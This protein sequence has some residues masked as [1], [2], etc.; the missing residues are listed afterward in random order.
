MYLPLLSVLVIIF[1]YD[2]LHISN[3]RSY[4]F[5]FIIIIV[6]TWFFR[7]HNSDYL[8]YLEFYNLV[9]SSSIED[10]F[11]LSKARDFELGFVALISFLASFLPSP[12][13][14]MLIV[15]S[16]VLFV[17]F[18][19]FHCDREL[20]LQFL[21]LYISSYFI[22]NEMVQIRQG[23]GACL[24]IASL[25][26]YSKSNMFFYLFPLGSFFHI[27]S[28]TGIIAIPL[29]AIDNRYIYI[30]G[31][32]V[33]LIF[34]FFI[35]SDIIINFSSNFFEVPEKISSYQKSVYSL[36]ISII[37][38]R[39]I[40]SL[41]ICLFI[42]LYWKELNLDNTSSLFCKSYIIGVAISYLFSDFYILSIRLSQGFMFLEVF[43]I[44]LILRCTISNKRFRSLATFGISL[45]FL[46][47]NTPPMT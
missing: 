11:E 44:P 34:G 45:V 27:S 46:Y 19:I 16:S 30:Y 22:F 21:M 14:A 25:Y 41:L 43:M 17:Y 15:T 12:E 33:S 47:K 6:I 37:E 28:I 36:D 39:N 13:L 31:V 2:L 32:L 42:F 4:I 18:Y 40:K 29:K 23:I 35:G 7:D 10:V 8:A 1:A 5:I 24:I 9:Q 3:T 20:F 38:L 26:F